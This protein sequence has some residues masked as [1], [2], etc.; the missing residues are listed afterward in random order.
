MPR[1][2]PVHE[3]P[4]QTQNVISAAISARAVHIGRLRYLDYQ[5]S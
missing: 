4:A 2:R 1:R 3:E 5:W